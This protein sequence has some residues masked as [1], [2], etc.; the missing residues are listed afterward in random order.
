[1]ISQAESRFLLPSWRTALIWAFVASCAPV[2]GL[3]PD[4]TLSQYIHTSWRSDA[5]LQAVRRLKQTPDGYLWLATRGGLARFDGVRFSTFSASSE[6]GLESSTMQDLVIDPD[7][8]LWIATLGGGIAHCQAGKFHSY[9]S[10]DGLP[11]DDIGSLYR[12]S[13]GTLWVG[14]RGGGIARMVQGRFEKLSLEIPASPITA[15]LEGPDRSLWIATYGNGVFRLQNGVLTSF[16]VEDG[17]PDARVAGLYRDHS[18]RI[19]T[20][21][22]KGISCWNG[23]RFVGNQRIN[24]IVSYAITCTEDRDGNLW[25]ASS[26]G[27]FRAHAGHIAKMDRSSGL[28]G[29]FVSDVFEDR[30][31]NLWVGTRAGLDRLRDGQVQTFTNQ[32]GLIRDPRPIVAGDRDGVW[33]VSGKQIARIAANKIG[34]WPI[35]LPAGSTS[36]TM[37]SLPGSG[38]LIG[39]DSGVTRWRDKHA[40]L[41]SE[42][43]GLDVRSLLQGRD[44]TV[45]IGTA[46]RGLLRWKPFLGSRILNETGVSDRFIATLAED[47]TGAIW[48]GSTNGGGLYRIAGGNVQHFGRAEGLRSL[49]IYTIFV[50]RRGDLWIGSSGGLSWFQD[51]RLRTVN[52]QQGLPADQVLAILEDSYDRLWFTGFFGIAAIE[53][54]SLTEWAAERHQRLNPSVYRSSDALQVWTVGRIFPNAVR[55]TDGH[56]WFSM[57][58]G[59]SEVTPLNPGASHGPKFP[60][61]IEDVTIDRVSH[62]QS[63]RIRIP[64]GA[65][66]IELRYTALILSSPETVRFRYQLEG[67]DKDWVDADARRVAFYNNLKPGTYTFRVSASAS[68]EQWQKSSALVLEQLP[69][70]YQTKWF[71]LLASATVLSLAFFAYRLRL[72]QAVDRI[73]AGFQERMEERTRIA[74]ELHDTIVQAISGSTMLVENAAEKIPDTLP[75]VK[76]ALLRAVDRLDV[77]LEQSRAALKGLR[78]SA[79]PENDLASQLSEVACGSSRQDMAFDLVIT[80]EPREIRE[81]I[82]YE[83]F[84][85]TSEAITNALKHSDATSVRVDLGYLNEL[86]ISVSDNG[87]GISEE[88]LQIGKEGHFGL[89]GMRERADRIGASIEVYSRVRAGTEVCITVPGHIAFESGAATSSLVARVM[90]RIRSLRHRT[91]A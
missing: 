91:L 69:F 30:E 5:G 15:F 11:S 4:F 81:V 71:I 7:G 57:A 37:L 80:G 48:A 25:I 1:V 2:Y 49:N 60:V 58:D 64:P 33:T 83:V 79:S 74:Q 77:A 70:F 51:G 32:E 6:Q 19:W 53:K 28:S 40:A 24:A 46:N 42:I 75:V 68:E 35:A 23:T 22:W 45:W 78:A 61:V 54:K 90:S 14:T 59:L 27:L 76:G 44:G 9:T 10:R 50:D 38:F 52:S 34:V 86:R 65:R 82:Q 36:F 18:G 62:S 8:S 63:G 29:D 31:G 88:V 16:S 13:R 41:T 26:S 17:L 39:S 72:Q 85:I 89:E 73:Q 67:V 87:K 21:G 3:N 43:A 56:L 12:D 20:A 47:P 66:S 84:R 55:S